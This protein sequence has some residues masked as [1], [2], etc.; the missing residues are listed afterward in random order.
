[1][2]LRRIASKIV[3]PL[4]YSRS[5][6]EAACKSP[7]VVFN[8][9]QISD[10]PSRFA[11]DFS[12]NV[13]PIQFRKQLTWVKRHFHVISP[14]QLLNNEFDLPAALITFDDGFASAFHEGASILSDESLPATIFMNMAPTEGQVFWSGLVVYLCNYNKEFRNYIANKYPGI[15]KNLFLYCKQND[16]QEFVI[17]RSCPEVYDKARLYSGKF[18]NQED[19]RLSAG[20]GLYLGNHLYNHY[21]AANIS[22]EELKKEYI[23]NERALSKYS[24]YVNLFSYPFGQPQTSYNCRTDE[25][26]FSLGASRIFTAFSLPN[27]NPGSRKLHR[28]SMMDYIDD[29][30]S[31]R[32]NCI[33]PSLFNN[34][35]RKHKF[36]YV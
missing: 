32:F 2:R 22:L 25:A 24:N 3:S 34:Y 12:L 4:M 27:R 23:F 20:S 10:S 35:F 29:E 8:Y 21:N 19:L 17:N 1:M 16:V 6:F 28:I 5:F 15:N 31:F 18:A 30:L 14:H 36:A 33:F 26:I 7:I 9:H 11:Q 13:P